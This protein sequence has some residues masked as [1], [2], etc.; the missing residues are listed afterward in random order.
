MLEFLENEQPFQ[1]LQLAGFGF[2]KSFNRSDPP[3]IIGTK[4]AAG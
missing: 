4:K 2:R 3:L 1:S